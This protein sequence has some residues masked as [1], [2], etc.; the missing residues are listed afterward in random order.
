MA[1]IAKSI[2]APVSDTTW[3]AP[4]VESPIVIVPV[5]DPNMVGVKVTPTAQEPPAVSVPQL[6]VWVKSPAAWT[7][8]TVKGAFPEFVMVTV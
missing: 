8:V 6:F 3:G 4:P 2:P 1:F 7:L 5:R